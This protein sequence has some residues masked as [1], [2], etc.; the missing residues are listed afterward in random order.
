MKHKF[1]QSVNLQITD[2]IQE[3]QR[4]YQKFPNEASSFR[5]HG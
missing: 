4:A 3:A 2:K 5:V 1:D